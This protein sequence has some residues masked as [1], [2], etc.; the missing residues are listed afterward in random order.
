M[1]EIRPL[2]SIRGLAA[3]WVFLHHL[4]PE[5]PGSLHFLTRALALDRGYLAVDLFFVLSGF[6][7]ALTYHDMFGQEQRAATCRLFLLHRFARVLPLNLVVVAIVAILVWRSQAAPE[8]FA[9]A[10]YPTVLLANLLLIQDW[11]FALSIVKPAWSVS[12]EMAIYFIF[13]ILLWLARSRTWAIPAL[14]GAALLF[15]LTRIGHGEVDRGFVPTD[16]MG[17]VASDFV[18]GLTGF[19]FGLLCFRGF[20]VPA[21]RAFA[22]RAEL[23]IAVVFLALLAWSPSDLAP[24]LCGPLL[25]LALAVQRGWF[26]SLLRTPPLHYLGTISYSIYLTH[27]C[28]IAAMKSMFGPFSV[29]QAGLTIALTLLVSI[30]AYHGIERP[31]RLWVRRLGSPDRGGVAR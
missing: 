21:V 26:S 20:Q 3:L 24:I 17:L 18:R 28:L 13:P 22:G 30:A 15:W 9:Q 25:V 5:L 23:A 6:V 16:F 31:A 29:L 2:T 7:L 8:P 1:A 12:V 11:G 10:R 4:A 27:V 19:Y 14:I